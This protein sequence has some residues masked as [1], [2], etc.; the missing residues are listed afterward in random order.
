MRPRLRAEDMTGMISLLRDKFVRPENLRRCCCFVPIRRN[1]VFDG[2][3]GSLFKFIQE[4]MSLKVVHHIGN[5][6]ILL[7]N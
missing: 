5:Y 4:R 1:S 7:L 3:R 2:L 6:Q